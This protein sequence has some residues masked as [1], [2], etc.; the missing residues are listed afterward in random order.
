MK[1]KQIILK[2]INYLKCEW[3]IFC[4]VDSIESISNNR[5]YTNKKIN[6]IKRKYSLITK[7]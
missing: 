4:F 6:E 7:K 2:A 1:S 3:D 5:D